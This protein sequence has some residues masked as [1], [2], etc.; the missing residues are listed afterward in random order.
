MTDW[1]DK[2]LRF[3]DDLLNVVVCCHVVFSGEVVCHILDRVSY[4]LGRYMI[5]NESYVLKQFP[6]GSVVLNTIATF[7]LEWQLIR[8]VVVV[9]ESNRC[10][11]LDH[12]KLGQ[13]F[14]SG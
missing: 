9:L 5:V 14:K 13:R 1:R 3:V 4:V 6:F 2:A 7:L 11:E 12:V 10:D 8:I